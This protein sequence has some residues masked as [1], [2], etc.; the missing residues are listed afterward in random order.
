MWAHFVTVGTWAYE[1]PGII[2]GKMET[3]IISSSRH[4]LWQLEQIP[5][6]IF[7]IEF[8]VIGVVLFFLLSGYLLVKGQERYERKG[9]VSGSFIKAKCLRIYPGLFICVAINAIV[10]YVTQRIVYAPMDYLAT[11]TL[12]FRF[13]PY[14]NTMG[15]VW[16]LQVLACFYLLFAFIQRFDIKSLLAT[17]GFI[18]GL[19][20][21]AQYTQNPFLLTL[22]SIFRYTS[23]ILIG[24]T[25]GIF[26][27][28]PFVQRILH[29]GSSLL[30][31]FSIMKLY[32]FIFGDTSTYTNIF[33]SLFA[34]AIVIGLLNFTNNET[35]FYQ[36]I[37]KGIL[38]VEKISFE[39]Y[40]VHVHVGLSLMYILSRM[41]VNPYLNVACAIIASF[42]VATVANFCTRALTKKIYAGLTP[43]KSEGSV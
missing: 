36:P 23:F 37:K 29:T 11:A 10:V 5:F 19:I 13:T 1:V 20:F 25:Y 28:E 26:E 43:A 8:G 9:I 22:A 42:C 4:Y 2:A 40:L 3:P 35:K 41:G 21:F 39:F 32:Q 27:K 30:I 17:Y 7:N 6:S 34:S 14:Q 18:I 33:T 12:T 15:V 38:F 16:Y 24:V 31:S